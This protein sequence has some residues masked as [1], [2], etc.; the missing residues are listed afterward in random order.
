MK[1]KGVS[2]KYDHTV[3]IEVRFWKSVKKTKTC[4]N[5][6][7]YT[8]EGYG[9]IGYHGKQPSVHR[10]SWEIHYGPIPEGL[11]VC[12]KCDNPLCVN[13]RHLFLGTHQDNMQDMMAKGRNGAITHP[14]KAPRGERNGMAK[15][16]KDLVLEIRSRYAVGEISQ[17]ALGEEYGVDQGLICG[18]VNRRGWKHIQS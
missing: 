1:Q 3:P 6:T 13:P 7:G 11:Y 17:R 16:T 4:W 8:R 2:S 12:H 10:V 18:I 15:L 9:A 5:W 14:E